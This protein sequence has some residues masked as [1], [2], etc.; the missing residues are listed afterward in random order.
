MNKL[1]IGSVMCGTSCFGW[2]GLF[3][4]SNYLLTRYF[5]AKKWNI[6]M[7]HTMNMSEAIV[8]SIQAF[9]STVCG[10]V[11]VIA[12]RHD[13]MRAAHSLASWYAWIAGSYFIYD[14]IA[15]YKVLIYRD[16]TG[17]FF[18][19]CFYCV[20][21]SGPFTNMR[22]VLS[23]LGLKTTRWY[24]INGI[25]MIITFALCRV[26]IFPYMYFAYGTQFGMDIFQVMKKI[27]LHCN[28]GSLMVLLP[29][30]HWLRLMV[31]GALKISRG[32]SLTDADEK[33]D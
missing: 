4:L 3:Y 23:R 15:M 9:V 12:C 26:V 27:P 31:L 21:L 10:F 2:M 28:L 11:V 7:H 18:V 22:V 25:L 6:S 16:G 20:E 19:G 14:I 5:R 8:S 24:A 13:V 32:A 17:D 1:V 30:I 33:I 29:Q